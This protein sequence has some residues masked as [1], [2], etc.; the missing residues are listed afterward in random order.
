MSDTLPAFELSVLHAVNELEAD[1]YP[2]QVDT[3]RLV[4]YMAEHDPKRVRLALDRL[5]DGGYV[6]A[7]NQQAMLNQPSSLIR[8]QVAERGLRELAAWPPEPSLD[9]L[10]RAGACRDGQRGRGGAWRAAGDARCCGR[11]SVE[12]LCTLWRVWLSH[13][14]GPGSPLGG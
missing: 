6:W 2:E 10:L 4:Q 11:L 8:L 13:Y 12:S 5:H 14:G 7:G 1:R 3:D 9:G